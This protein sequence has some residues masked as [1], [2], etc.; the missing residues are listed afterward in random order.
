MNDSAEK[1]RNYILGILPDEETEEIDLLVI[2]DKSIGDELSLVEDE[3]LEDFI[4]KQLSDEELESFYQNYLICDERKSK[5]N[6]IRM[7]RR[8]AKD[9]DS[10]DLES[11]A[12]HESDGFLIK[13]AKMLGI[14]Q[15]PSLA[16][17]GFLILVLSGVVIWQLAF[18]DIGQ[19]QDS[20][21]AQVVELNRRDLND[22][23]L[24]LGISN[25]S[26]FYGDVRS[27]TSDAP[28]K[29]DE[30]SE[31]ILVRLAI[32]PEFSDLNE[33]NIR[34]DSGGQSPVLLNKMP[35]YKHTNG[36]E[37]RILLPKSIIKKGELKLVVEPKGKPENKL[38]YTLRVA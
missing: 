16:F 14:T 27:S 3:L 36:S 12:D 38:N 5:L 29:I 4:D 33:F 9:I 18:R 13:L 19:K 35:G 20:S 15:H 32:P 31:N 28:V 23:S 37:L 6:Q 30:L 11:S 8:H 34:I 25:V 24:F 2:S 22:L 7:L 26:L 17:L 10:E 21:Y 1:Y